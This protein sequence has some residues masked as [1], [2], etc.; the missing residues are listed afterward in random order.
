MATVSVKCPYCG[1][2]AEITFGQAARACDLHWWESFSCPACGT[3][4]QADGGEDM[5]LEHRAMLLEEEGQWSVVAEGQPTLELLRAAR[6]CLGLSI[7]DVP[8]MKARLPGVLATGTRSEMDVF[9]N[10]MRRAAGQEVSVKVVPA[11]QGMKP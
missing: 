11:E 1:A 6:E 3:Q 4:T 7:G 9:A 5:P 10:R 8:A 2:G